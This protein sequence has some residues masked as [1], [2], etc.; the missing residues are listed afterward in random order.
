MSGQGQEQ[1]S[2][3]TVDSGNEVSGSDL[4]VQALTQEPI[5]EVSQY[6][7]NLL[8]DLPKEDQAKF[9][10]YVKQWDASVNKRF[11]EKAAEL[12]Q[13][14]GLD[15][16]RA[17][18]ALELERQ[19]FENPTEALKLIQSRLGNQEVE[20]TTDDEGEEDI[21]DSLPP[22]IKDKLDLVPQLQAALNE[23]V[24]EKQ[25]VA[26]E[27]SAREIWDGLNTELKGLG[28]DENHLGRDPIL[29]MMATG[30]ETEQAV[31]TWNSVISAAVE[32]RLKNHQNAP[33]VLG[34]KSVVPSQSLDTT[35][36]S[37]KDLRN[38]ITSTLEAQN[39]ES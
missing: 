29:R 24:G 17:R 3:D 37:S 2:T 35:N 30:M 33:G 31:N 32:D 28:V 21:Y 25:R 20:H 13:Y 9:A 22:T 38:F 5:G 14:E 6:V 36:M 12:K 19:I 16:Q 23:L 18:E 7:A 10:P 11:D 34:G 15:A 27:N 39:A 26:K 1:E 4:I 8:K